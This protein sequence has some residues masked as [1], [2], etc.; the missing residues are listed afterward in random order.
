[1]NLPGD[2]K[3]IIPTAI[4]EEEGR[5]LSLF[6]LVV[7]DKGVEPA[8]TGFSTVWLM[9]NIVFVWQKKY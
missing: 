9:L 2:G 7:F 8:G 5:G 3:R 6:Q 1:M 4:K